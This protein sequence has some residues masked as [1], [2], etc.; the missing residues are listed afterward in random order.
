V[1]LL[2]KNLGYIPQTPFII[3]GTIRENL[4]PFREISDEQIIKALDEV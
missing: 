4:D 1:H 3:N 2:R